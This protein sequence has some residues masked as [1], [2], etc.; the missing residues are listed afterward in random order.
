MPW[1]EPVA[2]APHDD[3]GLAGRR[4]RRRRLRDGVDRCL[5]LLAV[6]LVA[7]ERSEQVVGL[8]EAGLRCDR[9]QL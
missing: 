5:H 6:N 7:R 8:R 3:F 4:F 9:L 1:P 2:A